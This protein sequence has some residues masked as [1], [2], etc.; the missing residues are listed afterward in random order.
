MQGEEPPDPEY[1]WGALHEIGRA[2]DDGAIQSAVQLCGVQPGVREVLE[3]PGSIALPDPSR[4]GDRRRRVLTGSGRGRD[5]PRPVV[6]GRPC[7]ARADPG[8]VRACSGRPDG[9]P[10]GRLGSNHQRI[11]RPTPASSVDARL[12]RDLLVGG[13]VFGRLVAE[14]PGVTDRT[15]AASLDALAVALERLAEAGQRSPAAS[16]ARRRPRHRT[17]DP[18]SP[19]SWPGSPASTQ[20]RVAR[21]AGRCRLRPGE[22]L[23]AGPG[24]RRR[25]LRAVP[26]ATAGST[27]G[28]GH[29]RRRPARASPRRC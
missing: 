4:S 10:P 19:P 16:A 29:R 22:P 18:V 28:H 3:R 27:A 5:R 23:R 1:G 24:D 2:V 11:R 25:L 26:T 17:D 7:G 13:S 15:T 21:A 14:G 6:P 12:T 8:S 20:H 9:H